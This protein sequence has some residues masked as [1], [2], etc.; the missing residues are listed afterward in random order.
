MQDSMQA[1][2]ELRGAVKELRFVG[3]ILNDFET[4]S[5]AGKDDAFNQF[6][7]N[8]LSRAVQELHIPV[9]IQPRILTI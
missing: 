3:T 2:T 9:Y 7:C 4:V 1:A 6:E 5:H 8:D